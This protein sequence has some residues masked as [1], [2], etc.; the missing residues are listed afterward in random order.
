VATPSP[1]Q[2]VPLPAG[3]VFSP[4]EL[5]TFWKLS[6][7]SIRRLFQDEP[8]VFKLGDPNPRRKRAYVTLRIPAG[9][10]A[11]VWQERSR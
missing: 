2:A 1:I 10:A 4:A 5:A 3:D 9:V 6:E 11:R 7:Q 8:G